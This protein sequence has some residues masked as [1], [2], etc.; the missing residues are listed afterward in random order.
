MCMCIYVYTCMY[1]CRVVCLLACVGGD[2][3]CMCMYMYVCE[4]GISV[5]PSENFALCIVC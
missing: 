2:D 4:D 5:L 1:A 3:E